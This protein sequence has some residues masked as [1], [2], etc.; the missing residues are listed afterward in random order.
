MTSPI[1]PHDPLTPVD[2]T[3]VI[4]PLAVRRLRQ[5]LYANAELV[6]TTLGGGLHGHLGLLMPAPVYS[7][8]SRTPYNLPDTPPEDPVFLSNWWSWLHHW[9]RYGPW[10]R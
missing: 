7:T 6:K 3:T 5:E 8:L 2:P 10:Q 1:L 9:L 4:T